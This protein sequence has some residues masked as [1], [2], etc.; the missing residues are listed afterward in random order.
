MRQNGPRCRTDDF[1]SG[2]SKEAY[3][4]NAWGQ[5]VLASSEGMPFAVGPV[6]P[7]TSS[8]I[9][10]PALGGKRDTRDAFSPKRAQSTAVPFMKALQNHSI[11]G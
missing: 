7:V 4:V 11:P 9:R 8:A 5:G 2:F 10:K 1:A 3:D 6:F